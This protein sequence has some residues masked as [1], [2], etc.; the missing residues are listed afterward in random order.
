MHCQALVFGENHETLMD[1]LMQTGARPPADVRIPLEVTTPSGHSGWHTLND[2]YKQ[3]PRGSV[4]EYGSWVHCVW[5]TDFL[6][7]HLGPHALLDEGA[8]SGCEVS[9]SAVQKQ[10][11]AFWA[12]VPRFFRTIGVHWSVTRAASRWQG[13]NTKDAADGARVGTLDLE[14]NLVTHDPNLIVG[15]TGPV[16]YQAPQ[17]EAHDFVQRRLEAAQRLMKLPLLTPVTL[18]TWHDTKPDYRSTGDEKCACFESEYE[19]YWD[20]PYSRPWSPEF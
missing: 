20:R 8:L 4:Y 1:S 3:F 13:H 2:Q 19:S 5:P 6:R 15:P 7:D 11:G 16:F 10:D 9:R 17:V 18:V 14:H 12:K